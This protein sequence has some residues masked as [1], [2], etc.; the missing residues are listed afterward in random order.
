MR[1]GRLYGGGE[2]KPHAGKKEIQVE[3]AAV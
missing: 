3:E 1:K 2:T